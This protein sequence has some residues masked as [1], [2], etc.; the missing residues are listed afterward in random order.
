[1]ELDLILVS[2][3]ER[4]LQTCELIFK[5]RNV[6]IIAEPVLAEALRSACD[7]SGDLQSKI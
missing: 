4:A 7:I 2:P 5:D 6:P 3:L 1:M